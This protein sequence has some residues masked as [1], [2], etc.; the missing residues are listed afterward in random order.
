MNCTIAG[1]GLGFNNPGTMVA[2]SALAGQTE[3]ESVGD[4]AN[5]RALFDALLLM[6][7]LFGG[8]FMLPLGQFVIE[9][10]LFP[11]LL[12]ADNGLSSRAMTRS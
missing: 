11:A 3:G 6:A 5:K 2:D 12:S 8:R 10:S 7:G 1:F 4:F 9:L